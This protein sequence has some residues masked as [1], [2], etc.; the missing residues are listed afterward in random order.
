MT[1]WG[2]FRFAM[3]INIRLSNVAINGMSFISEDR[4][5]KSFGVITMTNKK[6]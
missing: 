2:A 6:W 1:I 5:I 4:L 3:D